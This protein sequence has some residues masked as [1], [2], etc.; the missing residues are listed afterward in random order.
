MGKIQGLGKCKQSDTQSFTFGFPLSQP[1]S[2]FELH[3]G[4]DPP[5][6]PFFWSGK[7]RPSAGGVGRLCVGSRLSSLPRA[8]Q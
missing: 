7:L 2:L 3:L 6:R 4:S 1:T 5:F 8:C